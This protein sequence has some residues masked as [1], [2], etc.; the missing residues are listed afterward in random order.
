MVSLGISSDICYLCFVYCFFDFS[1]LCF[2]LCAEIQN[3]KYIG[4]K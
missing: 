2:I 1:I 4:Y 3:T